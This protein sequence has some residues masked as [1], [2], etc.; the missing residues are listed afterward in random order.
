[1]NP[2]GGIGAGHAI[3][4]AVALA[5]WIN[6]LREPTVNEL[7]EIFQEYRSER[8][9]I[10]KE[11]FAMSQI[12]RRN[13]GKVFFLPLVEDKGKSKPRYQASLHKTLK[14]LLEQELLTNLETMAMNASETASA[15]P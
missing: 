2:S 8:Y 9:P 12:L 3:Q 7:E 13:L 14:I 10:V 5:N 4:D 15:S 6:V 1:M 11:A